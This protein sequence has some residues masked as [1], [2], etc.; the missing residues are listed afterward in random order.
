MELIPHVTVHRGLILHPSFR[1]VG[2][3]LGEDMPHVT[4]EQE[5]VASNEPFTMTWKSARNLEQ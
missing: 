3:R 4:Q 1:R 5:P 2:G